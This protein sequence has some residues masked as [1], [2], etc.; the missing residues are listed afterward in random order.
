MLLW[1][2]LPVRQTL[3]SPRIIDSLWRRLCRLPGLDIDSLLHRS[4]P[5]APR[6]LQHRRLVIYY[7]KGGS[8]RKQSG[9]PARKLNEPTLVTLLCG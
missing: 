8:Y 7:I 6:G 2:P 9:P 4:V 3:Q 1:P 5:A